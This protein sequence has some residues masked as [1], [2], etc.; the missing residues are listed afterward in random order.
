MWGEATYLVAE[1]GWGLPVVVLQWLVAPRRLLR[2]WRRI[3]AVVVGVTLWL[4]LSD[5]VALGQGVWII[6]PALSTGWTIAT[7]PIEE[8]IFFT[9]STTIV[10][11]GYVLLSRSPEEPTHPAPAATATARDESAAAADETDRLPEVAR[12]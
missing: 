8:I 11:Q 1:L 6:N 12:R 3:V 5:A 2:A 9:L 10:A 7:V 4:C